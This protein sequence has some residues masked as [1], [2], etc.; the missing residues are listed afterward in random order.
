MVSSTLSDCS[1]TN[2]GD[3][4]TINDRSDY[5]MTQGTLGNEKSE[6]CE[7]HATLLRFNSRHI[8]NFLIHHPIISAH[9]LYFILYLERKVLIFTLVSLFTL[10]KLTSTQQII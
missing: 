10:E 5:A 1:G 2:T 7:L 3:K 8:Y 4:P 9:H 6:G